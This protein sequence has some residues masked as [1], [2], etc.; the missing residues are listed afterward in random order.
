[1]LSYL[2]LPVFIQALSLP[3][4]SLELGYL[5]IPPTPHPASPASP[6]L[7]ADTGRPPE[8]GFITAGS[9]QVQELEAGTDGV[10]DSQQG[11]NPHSPSQPWGRSGD[12]QGRE[13][14]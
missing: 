11:D 8:E 1:M 14:Q 5:Y 4:G 10:Y 12:A 13:L 2:L 3:P 7:E 9:G 6:G